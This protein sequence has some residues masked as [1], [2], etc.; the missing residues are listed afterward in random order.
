MR[1]KF[2]LGASFVAC[3]FITVGFL[4]PASTALA[5]SPTTG[6]I[7]ALIG[8]YAPV[9]YFHSNEIFR[10]QPVEVLLNTARMRQTRGTFPDTNVLSSISLRALPTF[11]DVSYYLD[12]W[13][14]DTG[15]SNSRNYSALRD[16]YQSSLSPW[17]GGPPVAAY[18]RLAT[19]EDPDH[20]TIQYWFFYF[21]N[22][23][24]N[25]H[26]GDWE[27]I[28]VMLDRT[29]KPEWV[30][31]SQHQGGTRRLWRDVPVENGTHP[32]VYVALGS[33][34][35][36]FWGDEQFPHG[37]VVGNS[38]VEVLD[39]TGKQG[40]I[41]PK[42]ILL[43]EHRPA[44]TGEDLATD[45]AWMNFA[46]HWGE[47]T[48]VPDF[49]G[50]LGPCFKGDQWDRPYA[51]GMSQPLDLEIWYK[52]RL[53]VGVT[54]AASAVKL[55]SSRGTNTAALE[56][57][58]GLALLH[59]DPLPDEVFT[60]N[61]QVPPNQRFDLEAVVPSP[62]NGIVSHYQFQSV[63]AAA[64]G[65]ASLAMRVGEVPVLFVEGSSPKWPNTLETQDALWDAPDF[66]WMAQSVSAWELL[67]GLAISFLIAVVPAYILLALLYYADR[68]EKEPLRLVLTAFFWGAWPAFLIGLVVVVVFRLPIELWGRDAVE[69]VRLG[70]LAPVIEEVSKGAV[71]LFI[72]Y[73]FR[74]EI[75]TVQ[76]GIIYGAAVGLGFAMT[77]NMLSYMGGFL[78]YGFVEL[79]RKIF[80]EGFLYGLNHAF[81]TALFGA[82]LAYATYAR[83]RTQ[84][85]AIPL[86]A[87]L[88]AIAA[89]GIHGVILHNT[90]GI[91]LLTIGLTWL[92]ALVIFAIMFWSLRQQH[93]YI[94]RELVG[95]VPDS[96]RFTLLRP[97][98]RAWAETQALKKRGWRGWRQTRDTFQLCAELA[99]RKAQSAA[100][101]DQPELADEV[102]NLRAQLKGLME[103]ATF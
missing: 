87:L 8:E 16:F 70:M 23:W 103:L 78:M 94:E 46:G 32:I 79:Q 95:E 48:T 98:A 11:Q 42:L 31:Y 54:G 100:H 35:N 69:A 9:L 96:L 93:Q 86:A 34:A 99:F 72:V 77:A 36:Y 13:L 63:N 10:P 68:Y 6:D 80:V 7:Q 102:G 49:S 27:M 17:A 39:R 5:D 75:D 55:I 24:F 85:W 71:L 91:S 59:D 41:L 18:A 20:I 37:Q 56:T 92:G 40:R 57:L 33:H 12:V 51:W 90:M 1:L 62:E 61:I 25:K 26:E 30:V 38:Q 47:T 65:R 97:G 73:R 43:P 53:R 76:D 21:Y 29:G 101:P 84:R 44:S 60:A 22:D 82:G 64:A 52:N 89:N 81:Y 19:E 3:L 50:P 67:R 88:L 45:L 28:Q 15:S 2:R 58:P 74:R 66:V 4:L 83:S 14:G